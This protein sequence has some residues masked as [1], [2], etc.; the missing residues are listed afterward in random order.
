VKINALWWLLLTPLASA[1]VDN[2]S[3]SG[4]GTLGIM[5]SDSSKYGSRLDISQTDGSFNNHIDYKNSTV[6][7]LQLDYPFNSNSHFV[8]QSVYNNQPNLDLDTTTRLAFAQFTPAADWSLR[9]GRTAI[10]LFLRT[11]FRDVGFGYTWAHAPT[12]VYGLVPFR[13]LDGADLTYHSRLFGH[14]LV[15]NLFMGKGRA[16]IATYDFKTQIDLQDVYGLSINLNAYSWSLQWRYTNASLNTG[17][18][19]YTELIDGLTAIS[20]IPGFSSIWPNHEVTLVNLENTNEKIDYI[21]FAGQY[22]WQ[23]WS[24]L[25]EASTLHPKQDIISDT[26]AAYASVIY[27][28]DNASY[29]GIY[30]FV[31]SDGINIDNQNVDLSALSNIP[32]GTD[33]YEGVEIAFSFYSSNQSTISLG[34]RWNIFS[35]LALKFQWDHTQID[36]QGGTIWLN[37]DVAIAPKATVNTLFSNVS[38]IF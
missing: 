18:V 11:Q 15:S 9:V 19:T 26:T 16:S 10:N 31:R 38:F 12:E 23:H 34:W 14:S 37:K 30:S 6:L 21:S 17:N 28:D 35:N 20:Q 29:Y 24:Y 22:D 36:A 3:V 27:H 8:F 7:G 5:S 13:H 32:G 25:V 4:F 1:Q 2:L 33:I